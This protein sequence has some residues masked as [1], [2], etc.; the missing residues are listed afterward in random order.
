MDF[1][2]QIKTNDAEESILQETHEHLQTTQVAPRSGLWSKLGFSKTLVNTLKE[3]TAKL[4]DKGGTQKKKK[5]VQVTPRSPE[6]SGH[7]PPEENSE[8]ITHK[9]V[10]KIDFETKKRKLRSDDDSTANTTASE[11]EMSPFKKKISKKNF[12]NG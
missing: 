8:E 9:K 5:K 1:L 4:K 2:E 10:P 11:I 3:K 12:P 6:L 7:P